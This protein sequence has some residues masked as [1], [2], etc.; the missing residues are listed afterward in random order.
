MNSNQP[1]VSTHQRL[2]NQAV[3]RR[4]F[5]KTIFLGVASSGIGAP[6]WM[7]QIVAEAQ[8]SDIPFP[9]GQFTVRISDYPPL[10]KDL[11]SVSL[12]IPG[13]PNILL[14][15]IKAG[16]FIAVTSVCTHEGC[17]VQPYSKT[18]GGLHCPCHRSLFAADGS[19]I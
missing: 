9:A 1:S 13:L 8:A 17:G 16:E 18:F 10:A 7:G 11:G 15:R 14:T 4:Q 5:V 3:G 12:E 6:K 2:L 19:V